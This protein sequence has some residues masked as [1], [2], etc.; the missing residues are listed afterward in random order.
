MKKGHVGTVRGRVPTNE[1]HQLAAGAEERMS[2]GRYLFSAFFAVL[3]VGAV[4]LAGCGKVYE[5]MVNKYA[6]NHEAVAKIVTDRSAIVPHYLRVRQVEERY[7][8]E[9]PTAVDPAALKA[10]AEQACAGVDALRKQRDALASNGE[11]AKVLKKVAKTPDQNPAALWKSIDDNRKSLP[12]LEPKDTPSETASCIDEVSN[13]VRLPAQ[14][15]PEFSQA[16]IKAVLPTDVFSFIDAVKN[17]VTKAMSITDEAVRA[18][19]INEYVLKSNE[20]VEKNLKALKQS[21]T[22][23]KVICEKLKKEPPCFAGNDS[24]VGDPPTYLDALM[25]AEKWT[26]AHEGWRR[27]EA[28]VAWQKRCKLGALG[29]LDACGVS[30]AEHR[31]EDLRRLTELEKAYD[32]YA[33]VRLQA[34]PKDLVKSLEE[35]Q[36]GLVKVAR[37]DLTA[38]QLFDLLS[39]LADRLS[40]AKSAAEDAKDKFGKL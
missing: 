34:P 27:Y 16:D 39:D 29:K 22:A 14:G 3:T 31:A 2:G 25:I 12:P 13:L 6:E 32:A 5:P 37:G 40:K 38:E 28:L 9:G 35:M 36:A 8:E 26:A 10:Y 19:R 15:M 33:A 23:I 11:Y 20:A 1:S 7:E 21:D 18:D 4:G 24:L 17:L 30:L